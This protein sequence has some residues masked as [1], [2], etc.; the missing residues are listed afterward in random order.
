MDAK[1]WAVAVG[2]VG[3]LAVVLGV[4][5]PPAIPGVAAVDWLFVGVGVAYLASAGCGWYLAERT[6]RTEHGR[7]S[8]ALALVPAVLAAP[9]ALVTFAGDAVV[10]ALTGLHLP[11][12]SITALV[13]AVALTFPLGLAARTRQQWA[14]VGAIALTAIPLIALGASALAAGTV[15]DTDLVILVGAILVAAAIPPALV[16]YAL[17]RRTRTAV[18][19]GDPSVYPPLSALALPFVLILAGIAAAPYFVRVTPV[20]PLLVAVPLFALV[21]IGA[22]ALRLRR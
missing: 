9:A 2:A 18:G 19:D 11:T 5:G 1:G 20:G 8:V 10:G 22:T 14:T 7:S 13:A 21:A 3:A 16:P 6:E 4:I 17:G 12:L 15:E